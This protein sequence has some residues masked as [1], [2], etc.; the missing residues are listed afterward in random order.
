MVSSLLFC[1]CGLVAACG[2]DPEASADGEILL[3]LEG[4]NFYFDA[5]VS[6]PG[7]ACELLREPY[8]GDAVESCISNALVVHPRDTGE[9][10]PV[11]IVVTLCRG[12]AE[13]SSVDLADSERCMPSSVLVTT[14]GRVLVA[15]AGT[16]DVA[17]GADA[18]VLVDA[19]VDDAQDP[20]DVPIRVQAHLILER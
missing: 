2:S 13:A 4:D 8:G 15:S 14:G 19:M 6:E 17:L 1:G 3:E 5:V 16:I 11:G 20:D 12:L 7:S 10:E 18:S 9:A